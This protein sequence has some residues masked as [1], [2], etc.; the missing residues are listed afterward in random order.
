M[1]KNK[2]SKIKVKKRCPHCLTGGYQTI[3]FP[4]EQA[5]PDGR[6]TFICTQ[7]KRSWTCGQSGGEWL[8]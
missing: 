3:Y 6:P 4:H 1:T 8:Q 7:C 2:Q 5:A